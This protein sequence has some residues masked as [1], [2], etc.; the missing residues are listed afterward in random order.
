MAGGEALALGILASRGDGP[1]PEWAEQLADSMV[2]AI[3]HVSERTLDE[4]TRDERVRL[5]VA[6]AVLSAVRTHTQC[7]C[8]AAIDTWMGWGVGS[9]TSDD[10]PETLVGWALLSLLRRDA[11]TALQAVRC[12]DGNNGVGL[13][14]QDWALK[15]MQEES[16]FRE[17][18]SFHQ[19]RVH[20]AHFDARPTQLLMAALVIQGGSGLRRG[21]VLRWLDRVAEELAAEGTSRC[22][23]IPAVHRY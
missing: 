17:A 4:A 21:G 6:A 5:S 1:L 20:M 13:I 16:V 23:P 19:L 18:E 22:T 12:L 15:V 8:D 11:P 14:L 3:L 7:A 10:A 9:P 2:G